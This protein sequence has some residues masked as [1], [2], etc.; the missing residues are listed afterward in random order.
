MI[1]IAFLTPQRYLLGAVMSALVCSGAARADDNRSGLLAG[2]GRVVAEARA[3][4]PF[5][6]VHLNGSMSLVLRQGA[7]ESVEVRAD[8][9]LLS[10]IETTVSDRDGVPTLTIST[11]RGARYSTRKQPVVT[12]DVVTLKGL[13]ISGSGDAVADGLKTSEL[14]VRIVGSGNLRLRQL[15]TDALSLKLSGSGDVAATGRAARLSVSIAGSGGVAARELEAEDASVSIAGS[16]D[17]SV[18]ARK[19][20]SVSIAGSGDVDYTGDASVKTSIAGS[21]SVK[22]H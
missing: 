7:K 8:D 5:Q 18:N 3:V 4:T 22:K 2:S 15:S 10:L 6:A 21:G 17:A 14:Q 13:A 16:G 1:P 20:L 11:K 12:V 19:T 9:N